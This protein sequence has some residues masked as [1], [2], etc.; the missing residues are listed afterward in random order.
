MKKF[1]LIDYH[2]NNPINESLY[3]TEKEA[4]KAKHEYLSMKIKDRVIHNNLIV[5]KEMP[6]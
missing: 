3:S 2:T 1:Q 5:I 4:L 6:A